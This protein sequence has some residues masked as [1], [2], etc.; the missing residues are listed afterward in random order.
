MEEFRDIP[1]YPEWKASSFGRVIGT[2]GE[3]IGYFGKTYVTCSCRLDNGKSRTMRRSRLI[4]FAFVGQPPP[5]MTAD[6]IN[7][8]EK[9]N[10]RPSNLRWATKSQQSHNRGMKTGCKAAA[11]GLYYCNQSIHN[12][13]RWRCSIRLNDTN[14]IKYFPADKRQ[15]AIDWLV[16]KRIELGI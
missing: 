15:D 8:E 16:A 2:K 13:D 9:Q 7:H 4:L 6:H 3:E 5:G 1:G 12:K 10:D 11:K 14:Y